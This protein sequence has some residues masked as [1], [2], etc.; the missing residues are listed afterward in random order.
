MRFF[1]FYIVHLPTDEDI[2]DYQPEET[3]RWSSQEDGEPS[4]ERWL[5]KELD[6]PAWEG[7]L[8]YVWV[9]EDLT[10]E[11]LVGHLQRFNMKYTGR[12]SLLG[13][14]ADPIGTADCGAFTPRHANA[15]VDLFV[16]PYFESEEEQA[17]YE[18]EDIEEY[19]REL[20]P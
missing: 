4:S 19:F 15:I 17:E 9:A 20:N 2:K 10:R 14:P 12:G 13:G 18:D 6:D 8:C 7:A 16:M 11:E 5:A 3:S 1:V